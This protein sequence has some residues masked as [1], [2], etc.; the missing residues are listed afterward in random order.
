M[1]EAENALVLGLVSDI[2]S[3]SVPARLA[4]IHRQI[5]EQLRLCSGLMDAIWLMETYFRPI[6]QRF[7][8]Y[9]YLAHRSVFFVL[10]G[11][12]LPAGLTLG[13]YQIAIRNVHQTHEG[14][15]SS[16]I[17]V[18]AAY[19][20]AQAARTAGTYLKALGSYSPFVIGKHFNGSS[21]YGAMLEG[22]MIARETVKA[23]R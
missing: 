11:L 19:K 3:R 7:W 10:F 15:L 20:G 12:Q 21:K 8:E 22:V 17:N 16:V 14:R 6:A 13:P 5:E 9:C 1:E 18:W 23:K 2:A 4:D